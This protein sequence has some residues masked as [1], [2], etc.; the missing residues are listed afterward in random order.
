M[1][2]DLIFVGVI[3]LLGGIA[4][5]DWLKRWKYAWALDVVRLAVS[6][7]YNELV[8]PM[9]LKSEGKLTEEQAAEARQAAVKKAVAI[10][11]GRGLDLEKILGVDLLELYVEMAVAKAKGGQ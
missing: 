10:A 5:V 8:R 3:G 9:K 2:Q 4:Q 7:T 6:W 1:W 11:N